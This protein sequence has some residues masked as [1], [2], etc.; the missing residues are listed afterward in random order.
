MDRRSENPRA[1]SVC[2]VCHKFPGGGNC[3]PFRLATKVPSNRNNSFCRFRLKRYKEF[4]NLSRNEQKACNC[5][6]QAVSM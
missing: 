4:T 2:G 5:A 6:V 3:T 1:P